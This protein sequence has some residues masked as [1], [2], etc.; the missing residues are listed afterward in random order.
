MYRSGHMGISL[1]LY[2]PIL[3]FLIVSQEILLAS[4]G[5]F[6]VIIAA[7]LPDLDFR[8][9]KIKHR[10]YSHSLVGAFV[11]ATVLSISTFIS[12]IYIVSIGNELLFSVSYSPEIMGVYGFV[13]GFFATLSH[14]AGDII[15]PSGIP[16][17]APIS[18]ENKSFNLVYA[19]NKWA[20]GLFFILGSL[21]TTLAIGYPIY[22]TVAV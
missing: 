9:P 18:K 5:L 10:G 2:S 17:L 16:I 19:K 8:I 12:Y 14:Y 3:Y 1:S 21:S 13:M 15:T 20:N 7:S 22:T 11:I 4:V 6:I